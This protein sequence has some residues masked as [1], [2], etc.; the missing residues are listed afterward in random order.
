ML[1]IPRMTDSFQK[2]VRRYKTAEDQKKYEKEAIKYM[3]NFIDISNEDQFYDSF[4]E[5]LEKAYINPDTDTGT[6]QEQTKA[7]GI[8]PETAKSPS[9][10]PTKM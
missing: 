10:S 3:S 8:V 1:R 4:V 9:D 2:A 6:S 5:H 7:R